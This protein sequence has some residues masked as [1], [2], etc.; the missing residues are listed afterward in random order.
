MSR[1]ARDLARRVAAAGIDASALIAV[2]N[3][4]AAAR[5]E[6][7]NADGLQAQIAFLLEAYGPGE[8]ER[9]AFDHQRKAR[10]HERG[11]ANEDRRPCGDAGGPRRG[12]LRGVVAGR[13]P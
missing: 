9:M 12:A 2:V 1:V 6:A 13:H 4:L 7:I 11:M 5:A 10:S 8:V 3:E